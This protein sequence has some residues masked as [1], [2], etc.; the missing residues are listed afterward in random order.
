MTT[1]LLP[2]FEPTTKRKRRTRKA[3]STPRAPRLNW[4]P[5]EP[6]PHGN[7]RWETLDG[8]FRLVR[9]D[10][11]DGIAL[12]RLWMLWQYKQASWWKVA[13]RRSRRRIEKLARERAAQ[14][15]EE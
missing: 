6:T 5:I 9:S 7:S 8:M 12:P 15:D 3:T 2:G 13:E 10:Q 4:R 1:Q 14:L 11:C